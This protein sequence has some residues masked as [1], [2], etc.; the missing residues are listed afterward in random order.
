[1]QKYRLVKGEM[2]LSITKQN[3]KLNAPYLS[4]IGMEVIQKHQGG[5]YRYSGINDKMSN[6]SSLNPTFESMSKSI[7]EMNRV[8]NSSM[9]KSIT[10]VNK[11]V[12][13][14]MSRSIAK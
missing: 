13:S 7:D 8:V 4:S 2:Q 5:L 10:K 14:S 1:M 12:N 3:E 9:F 6:I 11:V